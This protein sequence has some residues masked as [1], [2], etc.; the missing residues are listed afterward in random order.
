[1]TP[2][3][4]LARLFPLLL[5]LGIPSTPLAS[6][7]PGVEQRRTLE[8]AGTRRGYLLYLPSSW[9]R[10]R[11]VPL[12]LVFHGAGGRGAGMARHTGFSRVAEREGFAVV[13]PD[14]VGRRWNDGRGIGGARDDVGFVRVLVDSL[15]RELGIDRRRVYATGISNGAMFA[16]RLACDLPGVLAAIAP[17]AGA[18]PAGLAERCGQAAPVAVLA[19]Q[20]TADPFVPYGGGGAARRGGAV[21][22]AERSAGFW[23]RVNGC[24]AAPDAEPPVDAV[25]DGTRLRRESYP[26]CRENRSV[27]LYTIEGGGHT[28]PAG[29]SS[30]R[31]I[32]RTSREIDAT[33]AIW[34]FFQRHPRT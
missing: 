5:A 1:M 28:W 26:G 15:E 8:V 9:Q 11:P 25:T 24:A 31:R 3:V 22:S 14:G 23:A 12:V 7:T 16:H 2:R 6:Q 13:Y 10:G 32:G 29:P 18:V 27:V 17:V 30:S 33:G 4:I 34:D 19:V 20:G 21:L